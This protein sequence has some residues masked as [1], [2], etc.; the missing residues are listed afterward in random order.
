MCVSIHVQAGERV[1]CAGVAADLEELGILYVS[2]EDKG[3]GLGE[4]KLR[5]VSMIVARVGKKMFNRDK[6]T[7]SPRASLYQLSGMRS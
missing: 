7:S 5:R 4:G 1:D 2:V 6:Y 3:D